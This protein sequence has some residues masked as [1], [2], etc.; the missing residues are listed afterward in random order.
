VRLG[1]GVNHRF[2]LYDA[3]LI[4][5]NHI[6]VAGGVDKAVHAALKSA[7]RKV[8]I[9]VEVASLDELRDRRGRHGRGVSRL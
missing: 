8:R 7:P 5:D 4:K 6:A 2:G 3:I 9:E 1:G